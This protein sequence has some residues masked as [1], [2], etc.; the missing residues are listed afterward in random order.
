MN[1]KYVY[2]NG[3]SYSDGTG[4]KNTIVED[5]KVT[6]PDRYSRFLSKKFNAVDVNEARGGE[7]NQRIWRK[8]LEWIA[9]NQ[10]KL[11]ET[12]FVIQLT[13]PVRNEIWYKTPQNNGEL[14]E[15]DKHWWGAQHGHDGYTAWDTSQ[16]DTSVDRDEINFD[17]VPDNK[18]SSEISWK[19]VIG[20]QSYF[21][22]N[23]IKYIFF[24]G[25]INEHGFLDKTCK[26]AELV[27]F[28][29]FYDE[30]FLQSATSE[31]RQMLTPCNH[32]NEEIQVEWADKLYNFIN[33]VW[34]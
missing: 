2:T 23:N 22:S 1:V 32:P 12:V 28:D 7:S 14:S 31:W 11:D 5:G 9:N 10:D 17:F 30:G 25:D 13:Y 16:R 21:E 18:T 29:Y 27:N 24:E 20:L 8:T 34:S 19:Y 26:I 4:L 33:E 15:E 3:C 6:Y